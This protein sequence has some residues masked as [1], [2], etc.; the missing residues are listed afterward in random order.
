[1]L[2][3]PVEI[4]AGATIG[5]G[6]TITKDA[7]AGELT[8]ARVEA[9]HDPR[10]AA[11]EEKAEVT[12]GSQPKQRT[13][14]TYVR[15]RRR[16]RRAQHRPRARRGLEAPRVSRLRLRGRRRRAS[17]TASSACAAPSA[18]SR[19]SR[20]S[21]STQPLAG[22]LG[23]AHTRWATHGG[24]TEA[25]AHPHLSGDRVAVIHNGII[26]NYEPLKD[27]L[28][29]K[30]YEF[31]SETD[32]EVA[33][34][35]IHDYL[36]QGHDLLEA[37]R[38]AVAALRR[39]VCAARVRRQGSRAHRRHAH[40]EPARDRARHRRELRRERRAGAVARHAA[41]H[42]SRA[43]RRRRDHARRRARSSTRK[44][45]PSRARCTRRSGTK[46]RPRR[47][48][49]GTSCSR[50]SSSSRARSPTRCTAASS[51]SA[52]CPSRSGRAPRSCCR[53]CRT[54]TSSRAARAITRAASAVIGSSRIAGVAVPGRDRERVPLSQRRRA[55]E[56]AVP[57]AVAV[58]RDGRHARGAAH[59]EDRGLFGHADDLQQPAQLDGARVRPR[60]DDAGGARDRRREHEGVHDA[61][62]V[63]AARDADARPASRACPPRARPSSCRISITRPPPSSKC[64]G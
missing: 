58:R 33:A 17:R 49:T 8:L 3:A 45:S 5:A 20:P 28:I 23:V 55:A 35:L 62:A 52:S 59:G 50:R 31:K 11:A 51:T 1:M 56:H 24:V 61:A 42:L 7:P 64:S 43:G 46:R 41:L 29:A 4:G 57:D 15:H 26:E 54:C 53:R 21:C 32:T 12:L 16:H 22:R 9:G 38:L 60:D 40:R 18:R 39:R 2:V 34:H 14:N 25:N 48:R 37:V 44:A 19:S 30:G 13:S 27:E 6:S 36:K 10:L 47:G 63:A